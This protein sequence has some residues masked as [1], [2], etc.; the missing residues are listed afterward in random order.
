MDMTETRVALRANVAADAFLYL[1]A[2]GA[3][4]IGLHLLAAVRRWPSEV[5]A[6][7]VG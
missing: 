7:A 6:P 1:A 5:C 4:L 2:L 3:E